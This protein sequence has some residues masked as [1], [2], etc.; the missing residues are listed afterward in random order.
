MNQ[1]AHLRA[2]ATF[3]KCPVD[4]GKLIFGWKLK[5]ATGTSGTSSALFKSTGS[6]LL[7]PENSLNAGSTYSILLEVFVMSD[8]SKR[9]TSEY[10]LKVQERPLE[11]SILG[12]N[13]IEG[14]TSTEVT[15][16]ASKSR[17]PDFIGQVSSF[18]RR[19]LF[20]AG[21]IDMKFAWRCSILDGALEVPCR[22]KDGSQ[23]ALAPVSRIVLSP[24][25]L[26]NMYP[27]FEVPYVFTVEVSKGSKMPKIFQMP[28]SLVEQAIP[29]VVI[30]AASGELLP[31]G[32]VRINIGEQLIV[33]GQCKVLR[34]SYKYNDDIDTLM[35][36]VWT[37]EPQ[38]PRESSRSWPKFC[39]AMI[40]S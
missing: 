8:P 31:S 14:S 3:S 33:H 6:T 9:T 26:T 16:D 20:G 22:Y 23:V 4:K 13:L 40:L 30:E 36:L 5:S 2:I 39:Q 12:G 10:S 17:D 28:M 37:F 34:K 1:A 27:T 35:H 24:T 18:A 29:Q 7:V 32:N 38:L 25:N 15:L 11:A 21:D 19:R